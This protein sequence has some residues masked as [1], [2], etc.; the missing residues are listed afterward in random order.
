MQGYIS[1]WKEGDDSITSCPEGDV[2]CF[3]LEGVIDAELS[4]S[5]QQSG[6]FGDSG[7]CPG[8]VRVKFVV[9]GGCA[10]DI[11]RLQP[12]VSFQEF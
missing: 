12:Q 7:P 8:R 6:P 3:T 1:S 4:Q 9:Q 5:L 2:F 11:T 10:V